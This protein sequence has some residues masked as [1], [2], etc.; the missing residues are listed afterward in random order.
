VI[1]AGNPLRF[2]PA[3]VFFSL[4]LGQAREISA[5]VAAAVVTQA[6]G[7][8]ELLDHTGHDALRDALAHEFPRLSINDLF[9]VAA[10][11]G[12]SAHML[13][14]IQ[15]RAAGHRPGDTAEI[16]LSTLEGG[17]LIQLHASPESLPARL[18]AAEWANHATL[19]KH[20]FM[21]PPHPTKDAMRRAAQ[22]RREHEQALYGYWQELEAN[23]G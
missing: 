4:P 20:R 8:R 18:R 1:R 9:S 13:S 3:T 2:P 17:L 22:L 10:D 11:I 14:T 16:G 15:W 12:G 7:G 19:Y 23:P 5:R 6:P 21:R